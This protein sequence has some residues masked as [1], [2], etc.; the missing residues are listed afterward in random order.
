MPTLFHAI[1][2]IATQY[3]VQENVWTITLCYYIEVRPKKL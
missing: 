1:M 3:F 2:S